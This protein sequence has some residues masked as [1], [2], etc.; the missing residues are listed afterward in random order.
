LRVAE[1]GVPAILIQEA[2]VTKTL[3]R[4]SPNF[5]ILE[6]NMSAGAISAFS[7]ESSSK[8]AVAQAEPVIRVL[9]VD[10]HPT[11]RTGLAAIVNRQT[12]MTLIGAAVSARE[13]IRMFRETRP[14]V[15]LMDLQLPDLNGIEA[16]ISIRSEFPE[17]RVLILTTFDRDVDIRRSLQAGAAGYLLKSASSKE[18]LAAIQ[19]VHQGKKSVPSEIA[20]HLAEHLNFASL[21]Q[22]EIEVLQHLAN[23]SRG[24]DIARILFI[25]AETVKSHVK[26]ITE[27]LGA[28]DR[29][30]AVAIGVRRGIIQL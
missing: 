4:R 13:G 19:N 16:L 11:L 1:G 14:D 23:G 30:H 22:R 9:C 8:N 25:S 26:H 21:S 18:L 27:K 29:T 7:L 6:S 15:T 17:A 3:L 28:T 24:K 20:V 12:N 2:E 10:D 5:P